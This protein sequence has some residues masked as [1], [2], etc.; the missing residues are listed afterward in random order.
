MVLR[1]WAVGRIR[2]QYNN[3]INK[4]YRDVEQNIGGCEDASIRDIVD[5]ADRIDIDNLENWTNDMLGDWLDK[6][7][8]RESIFD[9]Y[10]VEDDEI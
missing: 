7:G 4:R 2:E 5:N 8:Y 6:P 1:S 3:I 10:L 9:N